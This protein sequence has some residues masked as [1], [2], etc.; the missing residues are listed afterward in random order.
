MNKMK[1]KFV[2]IRPGEKI[3]E[4]MCTSDD[5][6][7]TLD[8]GD[9]Y[10]ISPSITFSGKGNEIHTNSLNERGVRV[11]H[12]T[13]YNSGTNQHFLSIEELIEFNNLA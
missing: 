10:V 13:E 1:I 2:G 7:L 4:V 3:H 12:G 8:F 9:H 6:Y 11:D 5:S